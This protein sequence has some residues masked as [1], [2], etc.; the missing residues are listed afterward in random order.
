MV[1][2]PARG[3]DPCRPRSAAGLARLLPQ[4]RQ[5]HGDHSR[6]DRDRRDRANP[7]QPE[8]LD[9]PEVKKQFGDRLAFCGGIG[10]QTTMPFASADEVY[11]KV[12][13]T[14]GILGP[15][16]YFPC[17]THVLEP[18]VPWDNIHAYLCAVEEYPLK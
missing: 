7:V 4:R 8:C 1:Q 17:P 13:E 10:T 3:R 16:G 6:S 11:R 18:E 5:V 12:Q 9:L 2:A 15:A 14:I